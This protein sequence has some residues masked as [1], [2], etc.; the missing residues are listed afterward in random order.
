MESREPSGFDDSS[1][2]QASRADRQGHPVAV[3]E[4]PYSLKIGSTSSI[5]PVPRVAHFVAEAYPFA[6]DFTDRHMNRFTSL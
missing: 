4:R 6:T 2:F 1:G 3:L 5:H